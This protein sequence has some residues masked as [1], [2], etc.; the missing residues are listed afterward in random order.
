MKNLGRITKNQLQA[1]HDYL[2]GFAFADKNKKS[3]LKLFYTALT[4]KDVYVK[5]VSY[6]LMPDNG[7]SSTYTLMCI[8]Q[9][10]QTKDCLDKFRTMNERLEFESNLIE[11]DLDANG[12]IVF[13]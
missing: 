12:N 10:G 9:D 6:E 3:E 8:K 11:I 1:M 2:S 13:A 7:I 5:Y 4:P